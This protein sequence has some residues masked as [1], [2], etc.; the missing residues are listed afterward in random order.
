[1]KIPPSLCRLL[2]WM[3]CLFPA[4]S[5]AHPGHFHPDE[6]DEFDTFRETWVHSH[7]AL[8][9]VIAAMVLASVAMALMEVRPRVRVIAGAIALGGLVLLPIL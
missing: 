9:Y 6:T 3:I 7:G 4:L 8:D 2:C 1:M 5:M